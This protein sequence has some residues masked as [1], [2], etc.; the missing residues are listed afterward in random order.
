M[1]GA[2]EGRCIVTSEK[3]D[4]LSQRNDGEY[5]ALGRLVAEMRAAGRIDEEFDGD[6]RDRT[7]RDVLSHLH[8]WHLLLEGWYEDGMIGGSPA[9]PADGYSWAELDALNV[10][11]RDEW[12]TMSVDAVEARLDATHV[13]LQRRI[14]VHGGDEL[15]DGAAFAWTRGTELGEFCLECGGA[16]YLWARGAIAAGLGLPAP[17]PWAHP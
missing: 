15:F 16:H 13:G 17:T 11:L 3:A 7:I 9:I 5:A 4:A 14:A 12:A 1:D 6:G 10:R 2:E 8:A